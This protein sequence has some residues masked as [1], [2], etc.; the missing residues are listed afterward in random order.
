[1]AQVAAGVALTLMLLC[2][3]VI[4]LAG[5]RRARAGCRR[6]ASARR[7]SQLDRRSARPAAPGLRSARH[8]RLNI[9]F[10]V[11]VGL[12]YVGYLVVV[13]AA[14]RAARRLGAGGRGAA[15]T[16]SSC[17]APPMQLTDIFNYLNYAR[18]EVVHGLNPYTTIPALEPTSDPTFALSNWHGLLSPY[19][20]LFTLLHLRARAARASP[21]RSGRSR[22]R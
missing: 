18:M 8:A 21:A 13:F 17:L 1:M 10:G 14:P 5:R 3:F 6:S 20:P 2:G 16:S 15:C 11:L 19:G 12:M 7:L 4:V 9:A 22:R